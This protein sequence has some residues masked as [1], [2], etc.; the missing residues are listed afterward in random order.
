MIEKQ[1]EMPVEFEWK[2]EN[3]IMQVMPYSA[4]YG[5]MSV[6]LKY[7]DMFCQ[8]IPYLTEHYGISNTLHR[9]SLIISSIPLT[10]E[11]LINSL[12]VAIASPTYMRWS[13]RF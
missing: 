11:F 10:L 3:W 9:K 5:R 2:F 13:T 7:Q 6:T 4:C 12:I 1:A 8:E